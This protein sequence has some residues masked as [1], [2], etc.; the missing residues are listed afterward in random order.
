MAQP[1]LFQIKAWDA[2]LEGAV[3]FSYTGNQ[4]IKNQLIVRNNITNAVVYDQT[5]TTFQLRHAVATNS[6]V[7]GVCYNAQLRIFDKDNTPSA[8]SSAEFFYCYS[9]PLL[10]FSNCVAN[11]IIQNS[12]FEALLNYAQTES[13]PLN[14]YQFILYNEKQ[15]EVSRSGTLYNTSLL[16]YN[17]SNLD[18]KDKYFFRAVGETLNKMQVDTGMVP[19]SVQYIRPSIYAL[20]DLQNIYKDGMVR[21]RS[22]IVSITGKSNPDPPKYIDDKEVDLIAPD[23]WVKFDE[24]FEVSGDFTMQL[25][26]RSIIRN[27]VPIVLSNGDDSVEIKYMRGSFESQQNVEKEYFVLRAHN[28]MSPYVQLSNYLDLPVTDSDMLYLWVRRKNHVYEITV[29]NLGGV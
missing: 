13:E 24:G 16:K 7:N 28:G 8:Y 27:G 1:I 17:Y 26:L 14:N 12:S 2:R 22:N 4:A 19:I 9:A 3:T 25:R 6:L 11:Q 5:Q 21:I 18:D 15:S 10:S 23:S 29:K 20:V